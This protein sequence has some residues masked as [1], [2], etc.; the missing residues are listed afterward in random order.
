MNHDQFKD[1]YGLNNEIADKWGV[2]T[3]DDDNYKREEDGANSEHD[4]MGSKVKRN[5]LIQI[6]LRG[7]EVDKYIA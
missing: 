7:T 4:F 6:F 5:N 3:K 2:K 1:T